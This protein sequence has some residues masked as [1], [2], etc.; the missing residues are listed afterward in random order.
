MAADVAG[1]LLPETS[2]EAALPPVPIAS[3]EAVTSG[4]SVLSLLEKHLCGDKPLR[5]FFH[6]RMPA[7]QYKFLLVFMSADAHAANPH[8]VKN[9]ASLFCSSGGGAPCHTMPW[10]EKCGLHQLGRCQGTVSTQMGVVNTIKSL[11]KQLVL[12]TARTALENMVE[13]V[14]RERFDFN[15]VKAFNHEE[16]KRIKCLNESLYK[17]LTQSISSN[18]FFSRD[19]GR[20]DERLAE[21]EKRSNC[22]LGAYLDFHNNSTLLD[23]PSRID[24]R[25]K[26]DQACNEGARLLSIALFQGTPDYYKYHDK[27]WLCQVSCI[28]WWAKCLL[29]GAVPTEAW[30]RVKLAANQPLPA[31]DH[32][33]EEKMKWHQADGVSLQKGRIWM[34]APDT[35]ARM[36]ILLGIL[37]Q[38]EGAFAFFFRM[39]SMYMSPSENKCGSKLNRGLLLKTPSMDAER[40]CTFWFS[41]IATSAPLGQVWFGPANENVCTAIGMFFFNLSSDGLTVF[42][43]VCTSLFLQSY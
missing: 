30:S 41:V 18:S 3:T 12:T 15:G 13:T 16:G 22:A 27:K 37:D 29:L 39:S 21:Q 25:M 10:W 32:G 31:N 35:K 26:R 40:T 5:E 1:K 4:K 9:L 34:K 14:Y 42:L 20:D 11:G 8:V 6:S 33:R 43:N 36:V 17:L 38:L 7:E 2:E 28:R 24:P 19:D 23:F